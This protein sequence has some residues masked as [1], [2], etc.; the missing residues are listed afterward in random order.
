VHAVHAP[1][2]ILHSNEDPASVDVNPNV[3]AVTLTV[4]LGPLVMDVFGATVST[5]HVW[6]AGVASVF[7]VPSVARTEKVCEPFASPE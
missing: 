5:A 7:P 1:P 2:S 3:A 6:L 4:P